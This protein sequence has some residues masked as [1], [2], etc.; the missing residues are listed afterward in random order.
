MKFLSDTKEDLRNRRLLSILLP[1][2]P[3]DIAT[4]EGERF[5]GG[6][7]EG[8]V[9]RGTY[10]DGGV[11]TEPCEIPEFRR[12]FDLRIGYRTLSGRNM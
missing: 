1:S 12:F 10:L 7:A 5:S 2:S 3:G 8:W 4:I 6:G 9:G 11:R